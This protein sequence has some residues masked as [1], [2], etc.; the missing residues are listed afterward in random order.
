MHTFVTHR[1]IPVHKPP[2]T[3]STWAEKILSLLLVAASVA[4][5]FA[6]IAAVMQTFQQ[7]ISIK[8]LPI[9]L[10]A[11]PTEEIMH[12]TGVMS[13]SATGRM[14]EPSADDIARFRM[15]AKVLDPELMQ[16]VPD[17]FDS[18]IKNPCWSTSSGEFRCLPYFYITGM[19][20]AGAVSLAEKL[21]QHPDV[22]WDVCS[23]C[24]FWGEEGKSMAFYLD[25]M[26]EA[27]K[28]IKQSPEK[29]V[30]FD[31]SP[32]SFAFY[33]AAGGKAHRAYAEAMK[34]CYQSCVQSFNVQKV[35]VAA[36]M[37]EKCYNAS[38]A[39]DAKRATEAGIRWDTEAHN[40]LLMRA[41]YGDRPP[42]LILVARD[43]IARL[44]SAFH[45]Y[46]HYHNKYGKSSAGFTAYVE[47]QVGAFRTCAKDYGETPCALYFEALGNREEVVYFH[48]D[49]LMRGMYGLFLEI[50]YRFIP[51][52]N[53]MVINSDDLF[54]RPKETLEK[55]VD[56]LGLTKV[57]DA[58]LERMASAGRMGSFTNGQEPIQ[59]KARQMLAELYAPYN[60][61]LAKLT[62]DARFE[63]WNEQP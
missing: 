61:K 38:L 42:K 7:S 20:H 30:L 63:K 36:C 56:F 43:P 12:G 53:W 29:K 40:P 17:N 58:A 34:P 54:Q 46:P 13:T 28:F 50:W 16:Q 45:G 19:F 23:G 35:P 21:R 11:K 27:A 25:N 8:N 60:T 37:T 3:S 26:K 15:A 22:L 9:R 41:V 33:W 31:G 62:G 14:L 49:Q 52:S 5:G 24:Q 10:E 2:R 4:L 48:A 18:V 57:D 47:D 39:A 59:P 55:V 32:S 44:Y 51:A 6:C 1:R